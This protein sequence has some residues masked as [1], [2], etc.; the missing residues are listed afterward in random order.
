MRILLL[1]ILLTAFVIRIYHLNYNTAFLDEAQYITVGLHILRGEFEIGTGALSWVGGY[2]FMFPVFTAALYNAGGIVAS[3]FFTVVLGTASVFLMYQFTKQLMFFKDKKTNQKA[4]LIA[5]AF[6]TVTAAAIITSRSAIYDGLAFPLFLLGT[7]LFHKAVYS[8]EKRLYLIAAVVLFLS[9]LAKYV[10]LM[11]FPLLLLIPII[12]TIKMKS[13]ECL[14]GIFFSFCLPLILLTSLYV[15]YNFVE[16]KD[17]FIDQGVVS[18][19]RQGDIA[20]TFFEY[21]GFGYLLFFSSMILLWRN[22]KFLL[23]LLLLFSFIPLV[24]H[25]LT[26]N[27]DSIQQHTVFALLFILP[28]VGAGF[29]AILH[30]HKKTGIIVTA[31]ALIIQVLITLPQVKSAE[32]FWP[33]I[34]ES[35]NA[36]RENLEPSDRVL[37]ESDDTMYLE[38]KDNIPRE[39][40]SGPFVFSYNGKEGLHAYTEAIENKYFHFVQ[41]DGTYFSEGDI[42]SLEKT[43]SKGYRKI[44]DKGTL[45]AFEVNSD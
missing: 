38:L 22:A 34:T 13:V 10:V 2:P 35:A 41:I 42:K 6:M 44:F 8:G 19:A 9:F 43:L 45:R 32:S 23:V 27:S 33:N 17:F 36:I 18:K 29:A 20:R 40:I 21:T 24:I 25:S 26:S 39:Q 3:R 16:L 14:K 1:C 28:A 37:A 11:F 15:G 4:G 12:L 30:K 7:V 31:L 5:A